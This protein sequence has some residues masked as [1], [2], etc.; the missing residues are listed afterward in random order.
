MLMYL[1]ISDM[2][3]KKLFISDSEIARYTT[4]NNGWML[5]DK[6]L[7]TEIN[8]KGPLCKICMY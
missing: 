5:A 1:L 2:L 8:L 4:E 3:Y 6:I 7:Q